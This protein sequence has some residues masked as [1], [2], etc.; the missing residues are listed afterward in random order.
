VIGAGLIGRAWAVVFA[1]AGWRVQLYG[2]TLSNVDATMQAIFTTLLD[3]DGA[4]LLD[5]QPELILERIVPTDSLQQACANVALVQENIPESVALKHAIFARIDALSPP[6]AVLASSTSW[7]PASQFTETLKG[8]HRC[9]VAHPTN[10]PNLVPLVEVCPA[11]WTTPETVNKAMGIYAQAGQEPVLVMR[12][13]HGFLLNRIQGAVLNEA[14]NLLEQG[15]ANTTDLD[16]VMKFGLGLRWSFMGPFETIDLNASQG[17]TDYA[18][19]YGHAYAELGKTRGANEW[20]AQLV[21]RIEQER[22]GVCAREQLP[23]RA[24]WRDLRLMALRAH[25]KHQSDQLDDG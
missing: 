7:I 8:R 4:G 14:L 1:R 9:V 18:A 5:E 13:I 22:R 25:Q 17:V 20:S 16:K 3:M 23:Q 21:T 6:D 2:K 19:R 12:E 15:Y 11:P 10:P 24:R